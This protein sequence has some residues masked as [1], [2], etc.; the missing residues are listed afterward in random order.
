[1]CKLSCPA[2]VNIELEFMLTGIS[3]SS[4]WAGKIALTSEAARQTDGLI[5]MHTHTHKLENERHM[6]WL[7]GWAHRHTHT[8]THRH[9]VMWLKAKCIEIRTAP[10]KC[11]VES[12]LQTVLRCSPVLYTVQGKTII[13]RRA[14]VCVCALLPVYVVCL[15]LKYAWM[16][17]SIWRSIRVSLGSSWFF[18]WR[19]SSGFFLLEVSSRLLSGGFHWRLSSCFLLVFFLMYFH[20]KFSSWFFLAL[21]SY[22]VGALKHTAEPLWE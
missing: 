2:C 21:F 17:I 6:E 14:D 4:V 16:W 19:F 12:Y 20:W 18:H 9:T 7:G 10:F 8:D 15:D 3:S 1:M 11:K 22:S 13:W 5:D